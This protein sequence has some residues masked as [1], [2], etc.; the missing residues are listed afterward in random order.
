[1]LLSSGPSYRCPFCHADIVVTGDHELA[2]TLVALPGQRIQRVVEVDGKEVHRCP[3]DRARYEA[4]A[5][6]RA[7]HPAGNRRRGTFR[8]VRE[9]LA[10]QLRLDWLGDE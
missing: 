7:Q 9:A 3:F 6:E 1:V 10:P 5:R 2:V 4:V 8:I